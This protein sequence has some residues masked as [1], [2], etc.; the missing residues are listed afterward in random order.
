MNTLTECVEC[1]VE[2]NVLSPSMDDCEKEEVSEAHHEIDIE[3]QIS[4][5]VHFRNERHTA[6][7][8]RH[9]AKAL[10]AWQRVSLIR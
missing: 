5:K 8:E 7:A 3:T 1:I 4:T 6:L 2:Q 9:R 10:I